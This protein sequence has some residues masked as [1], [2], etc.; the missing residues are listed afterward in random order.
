M[1]IMLANLNHFMVNSPRDFSACGTLAR[2]FTESISALLAEYHRCGSHSL[3][4]TPAM[5]QAWRDSFQCEPSIQK[6]TDKLYLI[7]RFP[8]ARIDFGAIWRMLQAR[9]ATAGRG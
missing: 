8:M 4:A 5:P 1:K 6:F 2:T 7:K 9:K 3:S